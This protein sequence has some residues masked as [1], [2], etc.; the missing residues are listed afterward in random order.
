MLPPYCRI[1]KQ[2]NFYANRHSMQK[3]TIYIKGRVQKTVNVQQEEKKSF[4]FCQFGTKSVLIHNTGESEQKCI[5]HGVCDA[6]FGDMH[7]VFLPFF[8]D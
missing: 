6:H 7:S 3:I 2:D 5:P 8:V 4:F 1:N